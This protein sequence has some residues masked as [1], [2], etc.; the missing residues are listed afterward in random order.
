MNLKLE[1]CIPISP[2]TLETVPKYANIKRPTSS[3]LYASPIHWFDQA[4]E[5]N[6]LMREW[7]SLIAQRKVDSAFGKNVRIFLLLLH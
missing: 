1:K 5:Q 3:Q 4:F 7:A 2:V 6:W